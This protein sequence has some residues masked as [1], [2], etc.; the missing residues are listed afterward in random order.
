MA[1]FSLSTIPAISKIPFFSNLISFSV[2]GQN[3]P[4]IDGASPRNSSPVQDGG[5]LTNNLSQLDLNTT[6]SDKVV[7]IRKKKDK[8]I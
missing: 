2:D 5:N 8:A 4:P 1:T 7:D 3:S 6:I